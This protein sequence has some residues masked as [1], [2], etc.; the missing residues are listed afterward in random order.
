MSCSQ[1]ASVISLGGGSRLNNFTTGDLPAGHKNGSP[2]SSLTKQDW[3]W[4][5]EKRKRISRRLLR[6]GLLVCGSAE[7]PMTAPVWQVSRQKISN[8]LIVLSRNNRSQTPMHGVSR[9][10]RVPGD[11]KRS[12]S[13][14]HISIIFAS[15]RLIT[16][17]DA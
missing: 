13:V 10:L 3:S 1:M 14:A 5:S 2:L 12:K 6:K 9:L 15:R 11:E 8:R 17:S 7:A 4:P 16:T